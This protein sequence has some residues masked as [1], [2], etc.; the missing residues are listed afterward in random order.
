MEPRPKAFSKWAKTKQRAWVRTQQL[1]DQRA[2]V[3]AASSAAQQAGA[4]SKTGDTP[5]GR[6]GLHVHSGGLHVPLLCRHKGG[7]W[8][9]EHSGCDEH[10]RQRDGWAWAHFCCSLS[11][12]WTVGDLTQVGLLWHHV[13]NNHRCFPALNFRIELIYLAGT[14]N[15]CISRM[16]VLHHPSR[17]S[18]DPVPPSTPSSTP[19]EACPLKNALFT[20]HRTIRFRSEAKELQAGILS[21]QDHH[22]IALGSSCRRS[23]AT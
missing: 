22:W 18:N 19:P 7:E 15:A 4:A 3:A 11:H 13:V 2:Q 16:S 23:Y 14:M 6:Y 10:R 21:S 1:R 20:L 5:F 12:R 8:R 9:Y 17:R